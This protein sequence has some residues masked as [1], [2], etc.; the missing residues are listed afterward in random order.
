MEAIRDWHDAAKQVN[1]DGRIG[2]NFVEHKTHQ[3]CRC[4]VQTTVRRIVRERQGA[5]SKDKGNRHSF[6]GV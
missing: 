1:K 2:I 6:F 4:F 3:N 5:R